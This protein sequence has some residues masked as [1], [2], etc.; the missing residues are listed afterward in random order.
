[1]TAPEQLPG[2]YV[3][4]PFCL[5]RCDYC[6]FTT[7]ADRDDAIP[8]YVEALTTHVRR[9]AEQGTHQQVFGSVFVGGGTP[10]YLP[11][12]D[13]AG[14]LLVLRASFDFGDDAEW[15]V[16]ANPET[17]T[18]EMADALAASG[19]TR[20]SLGAQSFDDR[21]LGVLG[22]WHDPA[23]VATAVDRLRA[24]GIDR[25]SLDLIYGS[26]GETDRSWQRSLDH[27]LDLGVQHVSAYALTVEPNTPYAARARTTPALMPDDDVQAARMAIADDRL[28][29]AGLRR[30]EVSNWAAP[31][32]ESRHNLTYWRG[33]DWLAFGSGAHGA[34]G[35]RR[36]WLVRDPERY[37]RMVADGSEPLGGEEH[38]DR[39]QRR[40]E[41][42]MMGLRLVEGVDRG[43]VAPLDDADLR[44]LEQ[45]GLVTADDSRVRL[46]PQGMAVA[47]QVILTLA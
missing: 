35:D 18:D 41:R 4:I 7:F 20:I 5:R 24:A 17:V 34:W 28:S 13:L 26:P 36:W 39:G 47:N 23:S 1:M 27:V 25:L 32:E 42:L 19:V 46:T 40:L 16:E 15:T 14:I 45:A 10:T 30:Y 2:I 9:V 38:V 43:E 3:H 29:A 44:R 22:R 21:V 8:G 31:G 11:P 33:G 6:D 37:A 12:D